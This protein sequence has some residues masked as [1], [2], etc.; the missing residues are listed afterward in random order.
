MNHTEQDRVLRRPAVLE[1]S[2]LASSALDREVKAGRFPA[3]FKLST[4]PRARAV[5]WSAAAVQAWLAARKA[6]A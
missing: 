5:G 6:A 2:G 3:P 1:M 4:D